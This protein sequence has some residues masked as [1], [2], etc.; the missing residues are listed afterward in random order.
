MGCGFWFG[1]RVWGC[2]FRVVSCE[3]FVLLG[4]WSIVRGLGFWVIN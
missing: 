2:R 1:V 3:L 4:Y